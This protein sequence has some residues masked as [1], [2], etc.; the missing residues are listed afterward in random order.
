MHS[1]SKRFGIVT[2]VVEVRNRVGD[3]LES[4]Q[5]VFHIGILL[6]ATVDGLP[7]PLEPEVRDPGVNVA[8]PCRQVEEAYDLVVGVAVLGDVHPSLVLH[9][10]MVQVHDVVDHDHMVPSLEP[11]QFSRHFPCEP[12]RPYVVYQF[13]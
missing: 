13:H 7:E 8:G 2:Q 5:V 4:F 1:V 9:K 12:L 6:E 3:D 10:V 11:L